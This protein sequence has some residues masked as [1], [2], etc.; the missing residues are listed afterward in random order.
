MRTLSQRRIERRR[1]RLRRLFVG[2]ILAAALV[3]V[4]LL[5][6]WY[7]RVRGLEWSVRRGLELQAAAH[8][9][10]DLQAALQ[11]WEQET[12]SW[13]ESRSDEFVEYIFAHYALEDPRVRRLLTRITDADFGESAEGWRRWFDGQRQLRQADRRSAPPRGAV[14]LKLRWQAPVGLTTWF[15]SIFAIDGAVYIASHGTAWEDPNDPA[16]GIVRVDGRTGEAAFLFQPPDRPPRDIVGLAAAD[17]ALLAGCRN[18]MVYCVELD[19]RLRWKTSAG[20]RIASVPLIFPVA[21]GGPLGVGVVTEAGKLVVLNLSTGK[22]VWIADTPSPGMTKSDSSTPHL[23]PRPPLAATL[24]LGDILAEAGEELVVVNARGDVRILSA[25]NGRVR[26]HRPGEM[27]GTAGAICWGS[28][29]GRP[30]PAYFADLAGGVWSLVQ[31]GKDAVAAPLWVSPSP[32]RRPRGIVAALR[33]VTLPGATHSALLACSAGA[34]DSAGGSLALLGAGGLR[35]RYPLDGI[36]WGTPAVA[37][38]NGDRRPELIVTS[39]EPALARP[40][41]G[42]LSVVSAEGRLLWHAELPAPVESSPLVADVDGDGLLEVLVADRSGLLHCYA[43]G[44][45]GPVEWG[46]PGG[47]IRN[48]R[49]SSNAYSYGQAPCGYQWSW[50]PPR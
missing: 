37:D 42:W 48:T 44:R 23:A 5:A 22:T 16:D 26:W 46:S 1:L 43:S 33:T 7:L 19:G 3:G 13:W 27:G 31:A 40:A 24:A 25:S 15:S 11:R 29:A 8:S 20:A 12:A 18:G 45:L 4:I 17:S 28:A 39:F 41:R 14:Q 30:G 50:Q 6:G 2:I 21:G 34:V 47:D 35:W 36:I 49:N 10:T 32:S 9:D 38:L